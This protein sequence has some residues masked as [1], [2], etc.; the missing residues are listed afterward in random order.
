MFKKILIPLFIVAIFASCNNEQGKVGEIALATEIDSVSYCVGANVG[1]SLKK[2]GIE[3]N[4]EILYKAI[5]QAL[6]G[7]KAQINQFESG[8]VFRKYLQN[9]DK[10]K[11]AEYRAKQKEFLENNKKD[12]K[13]KVTE[14]GLQYIVLKEG[15]GEQPKA[16]SKVTVKYKGTLINGKV[17]DK[18]DKGI[19][20]ALN[21]VIKG[22]TEGL[23]LMKAGAKYKFFIP[24]ELGYGSRSAG[25]VIKPYSTLVFEVE[26]VK[27]EK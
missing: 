22:W 24:S 25:P 17:F 19:T 15:K 27:I 2:D 5:V 11:F 10:V 13:V 21:G 7:E 4:K 1:A 23:Q 6:N 26:L 16:T 20:F 14:S 3:V 18:N 9:K 12:S 8:K